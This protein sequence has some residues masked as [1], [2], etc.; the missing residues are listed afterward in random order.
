M[1]LTREQFT[2][3]A[4]GRLGTS[5]LVMALGVSL[6][7]HASV[8]NFTPNEGGL[9]T[10]GASSLGQVIPD[11]DATGVAYALNFEATGL[12]ISDI[13]ISLNISGGWNGD[14]YAYLSHGSDYVVLLNRVGASTSGADGY[15]T[16][17]FN[18]LL[19]PVTTHAGIVDIHTVL[20]PASS[21][22]AY[23]ADGRVAYADTSRPQTLDVLLNGDPNGSWTLFFADRAAVGGSTL[24]SWELGITAIPEPVSMAL[25]CFAALVLAVSLV[26]SS[27]A[28]QRPGP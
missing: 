22:T 21:P 15:G 14:L 4:S 3:T 12:H 20:N 28:R 11:N 10:A 9:Y 19:E 7:G 6:V 23:A 18:I 8:Y 24:N 2:K 13:T 1:N 17:G 25:A 27:W 26:R 5:V 16:S